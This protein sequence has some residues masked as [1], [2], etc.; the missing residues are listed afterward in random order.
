MP[1]TVRTF[2]NLL[3]RKLVRG[4][5]LIVLILI[6]LS[7]VIFYA[8]VPYM[9][10]SVQQPMEAELQRPILT[11][12]DFT[13]TDGDLTRL[14]NLR[15][16]S[17][18]PSEYGQLLAM[19]FQTAQ[20][21]G[22]QMALVQELEKR[23]FRASDAEIEKAKEKY[24]KMRLDL[25][26]QQLLPDGKGTD[27]DFGKALRERGTSLKQV[28]E[29]L[30]AEVPEFLFK[31][32]VIT[33]K[34]NK[35]LEEKYSKP[36][37]EQVRLMFE[38]IYPARIFVSIEKHKEKAES[39]AQEAY[40]ALQSGKPFAEVVKQF[41]DDSAP[42][43]KDGGRIPG[44]GY[45]E[46]LN[47]LS[48]TFSSEFAQR[49]VSLKPGE[50]TPPT[51]DK[52]K[53]GY[54]IFTVVERKFDIP[55]DLA[56]N[57]E[58]QRKIYMQ[59]RMGYERNQVN[60]E[61]LKNYKIDIKDTLLAQFQRFT[62]AF[63]QPAPNRLKNLKEIDQALTP[64]VASADPHLREAQ[65]L[66]I[67]VLDLLLAT[68][69]EVKD[70]QAE[71][72][73]SERLTTAL[74]RFFAEGGED[75][76]LRLMRAQRLI[77]SGAKQ[78]ALE[79]LEIVA[80]TAFRP[81]DELL[82]YQVAELYEKA[83]RKDLAQKARK[84][85]E[86]M[87]QERQRQTEAMIRQQMEAQRQQAEAQKKTAEASKGAPATQSPSQGTPPKSPSQQNPSASTQGK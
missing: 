56:Q 66:Q 28:R 70:K 19:R 24:L 87:A 33:Q 21:I 78:K 5:G 12:G 84:R 23:G 9:G 58:E 65:W 73:Y 64:I 62:T 1:I 63:G 11:V 59:M 85:A 37:D 49:V 8:Y 76:Q 55:K 30:L 22:Q 52:D 80:G 36:T 60:L 17:N 51:P 43:V 77:E 18:P 3:K 15:T 74:N 44:S 79:D 7:M 2:R 35:S 86:Q 41:S 29:R 31:M 45:Y 54:Y 34:F 26:R 81:G 50:Y 27:R 57:K 38:Q 67:Q 61:A 75:L 16:Q 83:G 42:I 47:M 68:A 72:T 82:Q 20:Q 46:V 14:I 32:E 4:A 40:K 53:K 69:K 25:L 71:K 13:L 48:N 39:R 10:A 6:A